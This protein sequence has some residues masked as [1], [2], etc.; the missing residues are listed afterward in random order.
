MD[1]DLEVLSVLAKIGAPLLE[2][3]MMLVQ[4]GAA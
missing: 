3:P 1:M 4:L 2:I